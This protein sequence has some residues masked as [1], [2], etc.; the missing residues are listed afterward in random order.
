MLG[1]VTIQITVR[2]PDETVQAVD[3][4]VARGWAQSRASVVERALAR[5]FR[6][7]AAVRDAEILAAA[8]PDPDMDSLA[9]YAAHL[10]IDLD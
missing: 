2:L 1:S 8:G 3:E 5:E 6:R 9:E 4:L 10:P 7:L